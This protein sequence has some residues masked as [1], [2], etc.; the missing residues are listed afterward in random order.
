MIRVLLLSFLLIPLLSISQISLTVNIKTTKGKFLKNAKTYIS[1]EGKKIQSKKTNEN[2]R[3]FYQVA[4]PG[5]YIFYYA[6]D[7]KGFDFEVK[8]GRKGRKTRSITYDPK[9]IFKKH[10][11]ADRKN[12]RFTQVDQKKVRFE[13]ATGRCVYKIILKNSRGLAIKNTSVDLV[14]VKSKIKYKSNTGPNGMAKFYLHTAKVYE[15]DIDGIEGVEV[16]FV[17]AVKY[18]IMTREIAYEK[19]EINQRIVGDSIFQSNINANQRATTHAYVQIKL[20]NYDKIGLKN[21]KVCLND[22]NS[23]SVYVGTTNEEGIVKFMLKNGTNY[24]VHLTYERG[25]KLIDLENV[26]GFK[27]VKKTHKYRGSLLIEQQLAQQ[28]EEMERLKAKLKEAEEAFS[29]GRAA[30]NVTFNETPV[31][32]IS[33]PD[34]YLVNTPEGFTL[35]FGNSG[36]AG[37]PTIVGDKL[38]VQEGSYSSNYYC[39]NANNGKF[40]WGLRLGESGISP[41]VYKNGVLLINTASCSLYAIDA[42]TG[43]LLWSKWLA[44]YVYT[45]PSADNENVY[46]AYNHGG[47]PVVVSF[48]LRSGKLNWMRLVDEEIIACPIVVDSE[49]HVA[50]QKGMYYVYDKESGVLKKKRQDLNAVSTPT[51]TDK[52]I[53]ITVAK[54]AAENLIVLDRATLKTEKTYSTSLSSL[55]ISGLRNV[56]QTDQMNFNGSHPIIYKNKI[57]IL[58]DKFNIMAF[59]IVNET[60]LWSH[61]IQVNSDQLPIVANKKVIITSKTGE[62]FSFD[63]QTGKKTLIKNISGKIEG[64]PIAKQ[65]VLYIAVGGVVKVIRN[66]VNHSWFQWNKDGGHNAIWE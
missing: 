55:K 13:P 31:E 61:K 53:Y 44:G 6:E 25:V 2:G 21:E 54:G 36:K 30:L 29:S 15:I 8:E 58:T 62:V 57:A 27:Y 65:G 3:V 24:V 10:E 17:P 51:I 46:V 33:E 59:D 19:A 35:N 39:I 42:S 28:K 12:I 38:Y 11:K 66:A 18:S 45:T 22:E 41:A 7:V 4:K 14:D 56:D 9:G 16:I 43:K 47:Y 40:N 52:R 20:I 26:S 64:Q 37:T 60:L 50:S 63:I 34:K 23:P 49:I 1:L 48:D 5:N 32:T